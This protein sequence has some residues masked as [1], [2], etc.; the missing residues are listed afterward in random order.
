MT[1]SD[2]TI[3][4]RIDMARLIMDGGTRGSYKIARTMLKRVLKA[5]ETTKA[6]RAKATELLEICRAFIGAPP[7]PT[8]EQIRANWKPH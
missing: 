8:R 4:N 1:D 3:A 2:S 7:S 5:S 6:Q